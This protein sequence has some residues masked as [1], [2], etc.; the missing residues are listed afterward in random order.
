MEWKYRL[1][2]GISA[3]MISRAAVCPLPLHFV[4]D[5]R[6]VVGTGV[7]EEAVA[8]GEDDGERRVSC[9]GEAFGK[10]ALGCEQEHLPFTAGGQTN[11]VI[12]TGK[13]I[14][15]GVAQV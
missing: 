3:R 13:T 9:H 6:T 11:P 12:C 15:V 2:Q 1:G 7:E 4:F 8:P 14:D 5:E 10:L